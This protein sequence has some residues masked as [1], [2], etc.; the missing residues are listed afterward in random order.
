M[1]NRGISKRPLFET[2]DDVR[3]FLSRI[4]REVRAGRIEVHAFS[5]LT[6]HFHFLV[7]S[8]AGELSE[9]FR[10][11]QNAH[12]RRFNRRRRRDGSLVRGR[13]R[14][15]PVGD[16]RYRWTLVRYIDH[17]P[18]KAGIVR[19]ARDHEFSSAALYTRREG[20]KWLTRDWVEAEA[21]RRAGAAAFAPEV[22]TAATTRPAPCAVELVERRLSSGAIADPLED[23]V[24]TSPEAVRR[25]MAQK[26]RLA[27]GHEPGLPVCTIGAIERALDRDHGLRG[28]WEVRSGDRVRRGR[29]LAEVGIG[30]TLA[31]LS[32][33]ELASRSGKSRAQLRRR[34]DLH[35][36]FLERDRAYLERLS[37]VGNE[38]LR[39]VLGG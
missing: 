27:D 21:C 10:R 16:D 11:A 23:L 25:W 14:S 1:L 22:Y 12:S 7:R 17:N 38:A 13:F 19:R 4:A 9:A 20:P 6:T 34:L 24:G 2:R 32:F 28:L 33:T 35:R 30:R 37:Q 15:K 5:V 36:E 29:E 18:V 3:F 26:S 39:E 31:G 8:P